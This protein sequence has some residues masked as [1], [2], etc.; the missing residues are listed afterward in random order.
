[1]ACGKYWGHTHTHTH[2]LPLSSQCVSRSFIHFCISRKKIMPVIHKCRF[3]YTTA[4]FYEYLVV[5]GTWCTWGRDVCVNVC[6]G[7]Q[8]AR[9]RELL[10]G[11]HEWNRYCEVANRYWRGPTD[12]EE[13]QACHDEC[14]IQQIRYFHS[15]LVNFL[16]PCSISTDTIFCACYGCII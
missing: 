3:F 10:M 11:W 13:G 15:S 14:I 2:H 12:I 8:S 7:Q 16:Q 4:F 9:S 5:A 1:M 6:D